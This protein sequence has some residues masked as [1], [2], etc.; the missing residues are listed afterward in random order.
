MEK[1]FCENSAVL[2]VWFSLVNTQYLI[3][4]ALL[5]FPNPFLLSEATYIMWPVGI[6]TCSQALKL[7]GC[8]N[9]HRLFQLLLANTMKVYGQVWSHMV[10]SSAS[11]GYLIGQIIWAKVSL[12]FINY[13][14][15]VLDYLQ[16]DIQKYTRV[17]RNEITSSTYI[18]DISRCSHP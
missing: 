17:Q 6:Y 3:F 7:W 13:C 18:F 4:Y 14:S 15:I 11:S 9:Y 5:F 1:F 16:S 2:L 10:Y 8:N 12:H